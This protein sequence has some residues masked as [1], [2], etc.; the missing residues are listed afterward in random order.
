M[1]QLLDLLQRQVERRDVVRDQTLSGETPIRDQDS[2]AG[3]VWHISHPWN[4]RVTHLW[5]GVGGRGHQGGVGR[6]AGGGRADGQLGVPLTLCGPLSIHLQWTDS[7]V[8]MCANRHYSSGN[9]NQTTTRVC[10]LFWERGLS[11]SRSGPHGG[12]IA[13][14]SRSFCQV[15]RER[16]KNVYEMQLLCRN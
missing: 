7:L 15:N 3:K 12:S 1:R 13:F 8:S 4:G 6:G 5:R 9:M 2:T 11:F 14:K 10:S 16:E